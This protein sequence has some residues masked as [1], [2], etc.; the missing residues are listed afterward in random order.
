M[1]SPNDTSTFSSVD[2]ARH[3]TIIVYSADGTPNP[4]PVPA[5]DDF[6]YYG[7]RIC[8]NY[9]SQIGASVMLLVAL[10]LLTRPEKRKTPIFA[11]NAAALFLNTIRSI[12][13][14]LYFTGSFYDFYI[15]FTGSQYL[16]PSSEYATSITGVVFTFFVLLCIEASL[17]F[18]TRAVCAAMDEKLRLPA[19]GL[20]TIVALTA[21][22]FRFALTIKNCM[23]ITAVEH[24][25]RP[26]KFQW[27]AAAS[28]YTTLASICFFSLIFV[29]KLGFAMQ[30]RKKLGIKQFGPMQIFFIMGCQTMITCTNVPELGSQVLTVT[31]I[32]LP[33]SAMWASASVR[34]K[35]V[36]TSKADSAHR[37]LL[38]GSTKMSNM[39]SGTPGN[40][41]AGHHSAVSTGI[42]ANEKPSHEYSVSE[43]D[44]ETG[45]NVRVNKSISVVAQHIGM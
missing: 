29:V 37:N 10:L 43:A 30:Q 6:I 7:I 41:P 36:S 40:W 14:C 5:I 18:Q 13:Q 4:V 45:H 25:E 27:V 17:T 33:L 31:A 38:G 44:L 8:I 22:A 9:S 16:V 28:N 1:S 26:E 23:A 15:F 11:L 12:L 20:S 24:E 21:V 19:I 39:S 3:Q 32:F 34:G 35:G 2:D 42:S